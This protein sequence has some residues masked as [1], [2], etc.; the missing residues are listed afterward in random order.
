MSVN[1]S[2]KHHHILF[3]CFIKESTNGQADSSFHSNSKCRHHSIYDVGG[4][5]REDDLFNKPGRPGFL[6][7]AARCRKEH[8]HDE[9]REHDDFHGFWTEDDDDMF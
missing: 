1:Y 5:V 2:G 4:D 8:H 6:V 3:V 7:E 9:G